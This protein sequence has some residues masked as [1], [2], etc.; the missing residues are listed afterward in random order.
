MV[1]IQIIF[2]FIKFCY[3]IFVL[4]Y[5]LKNIIPQLS[6]Q[7]YQLLNEYYFIVKNIYFIKCKQIYF[8]KL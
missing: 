3:L 4:K 8:K 1:S 7:Y 2:N 5:K 6:I